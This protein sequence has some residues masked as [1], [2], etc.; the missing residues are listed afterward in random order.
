[1]NYTPKKAICVVLSVCL[2]IKEKEKK[3]EVV[4]V[5]LVCFKQQK[6]KK[7]GK[8]SKNDVSLVTNKEK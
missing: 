2:S 1:V 4:S 3:G 6:S 8:H 7:R 5:V